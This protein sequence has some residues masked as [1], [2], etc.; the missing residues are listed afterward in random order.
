MAT[1]RLRKDSCYGRDTQ[2]PQRHVC[3]HATEEGCRATLTSR[4]TMC[5]VRQERIVLFIEYDVLED[6]EIELVALSTPPRKM[7]RTLTA[8]RGWPGAS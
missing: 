2:V 3:Q 6:G 8:R 7:G 5:P 4:V 1:R